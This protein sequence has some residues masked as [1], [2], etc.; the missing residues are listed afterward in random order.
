MI[1]KEFIEKIQSGYEIQGISKEE[2]IKKLSIYSDEYFI[3]E[4]YEGIIIYKK[5]VDGAYN[6]VDKID[7]GNEKRRIQKIIQGS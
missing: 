7:T 4:G 5:L 6:Y 3:E 1:K 2:I